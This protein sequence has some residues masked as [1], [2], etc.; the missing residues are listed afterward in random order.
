MA[1]LFLISLGIIS[2]GLV[3]S[4]PLFF[5]FFGPACIPPLW[6][7]EFNIF[8]EIYSLKMSVNGLLNYQ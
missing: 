1:G 6:Y 5:F 8:L 4:A 3:I 2:Q 7:H